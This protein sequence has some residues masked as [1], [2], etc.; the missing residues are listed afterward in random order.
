ANLAFGRTGRVQRG[1]DRRRQELYA[2]IDR[3]NGSARE[4]VRGGIAGTAGVVAAIVR[5]ARYSGADQQSLRFVSPAID[6]IKCTVIAKKCRGEIE[7]AQRPVKRVRTAKRATRGGSLAPCFGFSKGVVRTDSRS[8]R[9]A[10]QSRQR[11]DE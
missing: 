10:D 5:V 3:Q 1:S 4:N 6:E 8:R 9:R 11:G 7:W 2:T